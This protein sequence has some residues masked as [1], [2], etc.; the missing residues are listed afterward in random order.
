MRF[1]LRFTFLVSHQKRQ[2]IP[3][4]LFGNDNKSY[5]C[6]A[7]L[8]NGSTISY[9]LNTTADKVRAPKTSEFDLNVSHAFDESVVQA[10]LVRLDIRK[11]NSDQLL[12]RLN[13][14]HA[15]SNWTFNDAPVNDLNEACSSYPH[16]QHIHF[17]KL[18]YN[19]IQILLGVDATQYILEPEFLQGP[20]RS[21]FAL[22]NLLGWTITGPIKRKGDP[23]QQETN[24]LSHG[25]RTF[26]N[27]LTKLTVDTERHL[28]ECV[29]SFWKIEN[30]G[31]E[32]EETADTSTDSKR[33]V[34]ILQ[35]TIHHIGDRYEIGLHWKQDSKLENNYPVAKAQLDSLPR[36]L[37][38]DIELKQL[39]EKTLETDLEKG[40]VKPV[41][42]TYPLPEKI[43]YLTHHPVNNP[44]KPGKVRRV[45]N[46]ASAFRKQSLNKNFLSGPDLLNNLV[47]LL[48][49][50]RQDS[51]AVMADKEAMFMQICIRTED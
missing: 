4:T 36:R 24:F 3:V 17:P 31:T 30:T 43:W 10:N 25:Y 22:R 47:G 44:N 39:Y 32:F 50:F 41:T 49:R 45:A 18:S 26:D 12:F 11:F 46:A 5:N 7:I 29:T 13:Y 27:V 51:V 20:S 21:P 33:T 40:Y 37:N 1:Q 38:K 6:Y 15:L 9:V 2:V 28:S 48:L 16:H 34:L 35:D 42:F 19:K 8:D 23:I 14:V